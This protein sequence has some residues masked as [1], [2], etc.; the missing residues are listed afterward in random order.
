MAENKQSFLLYCDT[1]HTV[2]KLTDAQAGLLFKHLLRYVNDQDPAPPDI[3]TEIAFEPIKQSLKRDLKKYESKREQNKKNALKRWN[4]NASDG[5][6]DNAND[7]VSVSDSV[8]VSDSDI[9]SV[10]EKV[11]NDAQKN[12]L[13]ESN[14]FRAPK[15]PKF[16]EVHRIFLQNGG[17]E[18]M[19]K[20]FFDANTATDWYYKGSPITNFSSMVPSYIRNWKTKENGKTH[21]RIT[22]ASKPQP[23]HPDH[24]G[25]AI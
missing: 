21:Q 13:K 22:A 8:I 1:I 16:E 11:S 4:A 23:G 24:K 5:I 9:V 6:K 18:E 12:F 10:N 14:L 20:T 2:E 19:A 17:T 7:A 15:I 25:T 3:I